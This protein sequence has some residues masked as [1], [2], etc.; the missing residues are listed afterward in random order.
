[1]GKVGGLVWGLV[2]RVRQLPGHLGF[3]FG[4]PHINLLVRDWTVVPAQSRKSRYVRRRLLVRTRAGV[5]LFVIRGRAA[6]G[7]Y[8]VA[9]G[10]RSCQSLHHRQHPVVLLPQLLVVVLSLLDASTLLVEKPALYF[11]FVH[12][13][14]DALTHHS[15]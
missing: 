2:Q 8:A 5:A 14:L 7:H 3:F 1:M 15:R 12:E 10:R 13:V 9:D 6:E 4:I 11:Q